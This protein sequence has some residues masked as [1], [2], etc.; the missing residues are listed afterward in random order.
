MKKIIIVP[1]PL[2]D[3]GFLVTDLLCTKLIA[4]GFLPYVDSALL[5]ER[6]GVNKY[7]AFPSDADLIIVV[8]GDGSF[9]DASRVAIEHDIPIV[10][11]N[12]GRL[13]YLSEV[14]PANLDVL[15]KLAT[16][17]YFEEEKMLLSVV[18][19]NGKFLDAFAVN[20]VI[21]SH[22]GGLGI[23]DYLLT[24]SNGNSISYR[25]DALIFSTPQG[26]TAYSLSSGGPIVA[27]NVKGILVTP[28]APHSFFNRSVI[29]DDSEKLI[30]TNTGAESVKLSIDGRACLYINPGEACGVCRAPGT[31]KT[32]SFAKNIMFTKLFKK[33][34]LFERIE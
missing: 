11:V 15:D 29:F 19:S 14:E 13:G 6:E 18:D 33:M 12:M 27:H 17:E 3:S 9:I 7:N 34:S 2:K 23:S 24:D 10:G 21:V 8:G 16:G 5:F 30:V 26:S 1:N 22:S 32:I 25:A 4:L 31:L 28:V 20:D